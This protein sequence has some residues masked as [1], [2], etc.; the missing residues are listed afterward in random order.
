MPLEST[1]GWPVSQAAASSGVLVISPEA[2]FQAATPT[3]F[4]RSTASRENGEDRNSRPFS[5]ACR[6]KPAHW[7]SENSMRFQ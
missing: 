2:I 5:S 1:T 7:S 3:R 6:R 4:R